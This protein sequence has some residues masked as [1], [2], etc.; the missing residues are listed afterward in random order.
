VAKKLIDI[1][2]NIDSSGPRF[3][4]YLHDLIHDDIIEKLDELCLTTEVY[5]FSGI[6]RNYFLNIY[7]K[8]D[9]DIVI[10]GDID[11]Y[12]EFKGYSIT[13][14]SFGG[15]KIMFPSGPLDLWF[16]NDTW[17]FQH[18]Q[19]T[20]N[21]NLEK[22]IPDTS[23]FNFSAIIFSLN[24]SEFYYSRHF[25]RFLKY[26]KLDF[27]YKLNPN[28]PLCIINTLYY[29]NKYNLNISERLL[30]FTRELYQT[31]SYEY[32]KVQTKHFGEIIYSNEEIKHFFNQPYET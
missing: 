10:N 8:R 7:Q 30:N 22:K 26:R 27:V 32:E 17:A 21:F 14:N 1:K 13:V 12:N 16:I 29:S 25:L 19:K 9:I 2:K 24:K 5:L 11:I 4:K 3:Y 6:I 15:Y 28:Y 23:F 31:H 18:H 20:L